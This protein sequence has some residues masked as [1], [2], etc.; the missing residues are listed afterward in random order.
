MAHYLLRSTTRRLVGRHYPLGSGEDWSAL[1]N[2]SGNYDIASMDINIMSDNVA[3]KWRLLCRHI[4]TYNLSSIPDDLVESDIVVGQLICGGYSKED[5]LGILPSICVYGAT[6]TNP[7]SI[8]AADYSNCG[9]TPFSDA[10]AYNDWVVSGNN[11]FSLNADFITALL[12]ALA[13]DYISICV[14]ESLYDIGASTPAW[15]E[16]LYSF[17][18]SFPNFIY[19]KINYKSVPTISTVDATNILQNTATFNG[20]LADDGE[21]STDIRFVYGLDTGINTAEVL[22]ISET[23]I[24][25]D[26]DATTAIPVNTVINLDGEDMLVTGTGT[27]LTVTRGYN[28]TT[29]VTHETNKDIIKWLIYTDW[30]YGVS[31]GS[32]SANITGLSSGTTYHFR[33]IAK[34]IKGTVYGGDKTFTTLGLGRSYGFIIG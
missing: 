3:S 12:N 13:S 2:G 8:V 7:L 32:L 28:G 27:T 9:T 25:C 18:L 23:G 26:A 16:S 22:D 6:P 29:A 4:Q 14:R 33:A 17:I 20:N 31:E 10:I 30:Q 24:D 15:S 5:N 34:N 21:L 19:L 1:E 11:I